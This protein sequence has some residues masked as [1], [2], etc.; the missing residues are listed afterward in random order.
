MLRLPSDK[1]IKCFEFMFRRDLY[2][3]K[4]ESLGALLIREYLGSSSHYPYPFHGVLLA[5]T[6]ILGGNC[7]DIKSTNEPYS[8]S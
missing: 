5:R 7:P 1:L 3:K 8:Y 6:S 4:T 2:E